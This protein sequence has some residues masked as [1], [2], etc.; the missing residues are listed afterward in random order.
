[1]MVLL[2]Q[3][4]AMAKTQVPSSTTRLAA[5]VYPRQLA[6]RQL[7]ISP[8]CRRYTTAPGSSPMCVCPCS[9]TETLVTHEIYA[10]RGN[11]VT[12]SRLKALKRELADTEAEVDKVEKKIEEV[13]QEKAECKYLLSEYVAKCLTV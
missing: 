4:L 2:R 12:A 5:S 6:R 3:V 9:C 1:M 13:Q 7:A 8:W 11:A 10:F